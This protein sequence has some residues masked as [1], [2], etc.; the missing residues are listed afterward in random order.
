MK[1]YMSLDVCFILLLTAVM[2]AQ[3]S[4]TPDDAVNY[5]ALKG[6]ASHFIAKTC[7]TDM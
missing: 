4:D 5:R 7:V 1:R 3:A 2:T 6:A